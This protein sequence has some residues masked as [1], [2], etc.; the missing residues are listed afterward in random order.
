MRFFATVLLLVAA[1]LGLYG[2]DNDGSPDA[3]PLPPIPQ[4]RYVFPETEIK[5]M[6]NFKEA[7]GFLDI[8]EYRNLLHPDFKFFFLE[9]DITTLG[10]LSDHL[11]RENDLDATVNIFQGEPI[12]NPGAIPPEPDPIP[13][14]S[15][16]DVSLLEP[17]TIWEPST[18][19][20]FP[21]AQQA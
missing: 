4:P 9:H 8:D 14:V 18:H 12:P 6:A 15:D 1:L 11:D 3:P 21:T 17:V 13:A 2:C 5:A 16:I 7:Y 20:D 10:L 19:S